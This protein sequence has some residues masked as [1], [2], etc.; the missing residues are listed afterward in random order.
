MLNIQPHSCN[1]SAVLLCCTLSQCPKLCVGL[2]YVFLELQ[3]KMGYD[4]SR[5]FQADM[6][7]LRTDHIIV[8]VHTEMQMS[9][10]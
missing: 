6:L 5:Y 4:I 2:P 7:T 8:I 3:M 10:H 1:S 9:A